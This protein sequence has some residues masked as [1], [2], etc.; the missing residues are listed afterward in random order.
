MTCE[1]IQRPGFV[2]CSGVGNYD[3]NRACIVSAA[4]AC[5]RL[6]RGEPLG[7]ATDI[8]ECACQIAR[9]YLIELNDSNLWFSDCHRTRVLSPLIELLP[10]T[11]NDALETKRM[12][13][14][15]DATVRVILAQALVRAGVYNRLDGLPEIKDKASAITAYELLYP[16]YNLTHNDSVRIALD[17]VKYCVDT[18]NLVG[19][20]PKLIASKMAL[21]ASLTC[22]LVDSYNEYVANQCVDLVK[23]V[24]VT[25]E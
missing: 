3:N 4:V 13:M 5:W 23:R 17:S 16:L 7:E 6:K 19:Y 25:R 22:Y 21:S 1:L 12:Y 18:L 14:F 10:E 24:L 2:L 8:L 9:A 20:Y 15:V 11:R